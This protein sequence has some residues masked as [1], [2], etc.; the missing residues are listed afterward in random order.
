VR[1]LTENTHCS[2]IVKITP[3]F[4]KLFSGHSTWFL[5]SGMNRIYKH[6]TL[7]FATSMTMAK[8]VSFSSYPGAVA[9]IDD[10]YITSNGLN[11]METTNSIMDTDLY[12]L[13]KPQTLL[14]WQRTVI[15]NRLANSGSQWAQLF[16]KYNSGTYNNQWI[17]VDYKN[18]N[19]GQFVK[20]NLLWIL[21]QIPG[22][23]E[24]ADATNIL[25]FGYW[26]SYNIPYFKSI[27][28]MSG[29][30]EYVKK[31][32]NFF[33]YE[34]CPRATIFR[35]DQVKVKDFDGLQYI[36]RYND[37]KNDPLSSG[38]PRYSICGRN[39]LDPAI[40]AAGGCSD[41]KSISSDYALK[42]VAFAINGP[43]AQNQPPFNWAQFPSAPHLGMPQK[44]NFDWVKMDPNEATFY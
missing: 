2:S 8:S 30:P 34:L 43:T 44:Y 10:F 14:T 4:S 16:S 36:L 6:Y 28:N 18:F 19:S 3:D 37:Y 23:I 1:Y 27:F 24:A 31:Y 11:V 32:G 17:I 12:D 9:S 13:V 39:D 22:Y 21:E 20:E 29:Y 40:P 5:Y 41:S 25:N 15:A 7:N 38:N 42:Q 33:S 35:R 26:P